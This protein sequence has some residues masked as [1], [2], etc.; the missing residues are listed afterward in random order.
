M[1]LQRRGSFPVTIFDLISVQL[2]INYARTFLL[3]TVDVNVVVC[4]SG[5]KTFNLLPQKNTQGY[6]YTHKKNSPPLLPPL[7]T[8]R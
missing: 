4:L 1:C 6:I 7:D 5:E 8:R 3:T 2:L